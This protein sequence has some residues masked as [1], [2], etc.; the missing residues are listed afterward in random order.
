MYTF[1]YALSSSSESHFGG[2]AFPIPHWRMGE[3]DIGGGLAILLGTDQ[4]SFYP[5]SK[6][7]D[8]SVKS[9]II[10]ASSRE[11]SKYTFLHS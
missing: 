6:S 8:H 5:L 7:L 10:L 2:H 1:E 11:L 3:G 9:L 4:E